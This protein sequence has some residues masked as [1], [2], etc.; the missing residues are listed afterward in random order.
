MFGTMKSRYMDWMLVICL[1]VVSFLPVIFGDR[2]FCGYGL[3]NALK[4]L[5]HGKYHSRLGPNV[6]L[7]LQT[8]SR[9]KREIFDSSGIVEECCERP[10][11][12]SA[13]T[14]YCAEPP[15]QPLLN[16]FGSSP[17]FAD[18]QNK[19]ALSSLLPPNSVVALQSAPSPEAASIFSR[20][21]S[22]VQENEPFDLSPLMEESSTRQIAEPTRQKRFSRNYYRRKRKVLPADLSI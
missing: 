2:R 20:F 17:L 10:C 5:C 11:S 16:L 14:K 9:R 15:G 1:A 4:L 7:A 19:T 13:L 18:N 21:P 6:Q 12:I 8:R 3:S 22:A